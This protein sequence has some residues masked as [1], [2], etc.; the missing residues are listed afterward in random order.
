MRVATSRAYDAELT[1]YNLTRACTGTGSRAEARAQGEHR[2]NQLS[3]LE[4]HIDTPS[5]NWKAVVSGSSSFGFIRFCITAGT[6]A[7]NR[8]KSSSSVPVIVIVSV[9]LLRPL[10]SASVPLCVR[11]PFYSLRSLSTHEL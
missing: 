9:Q 1:V 3:V 4:K 5:S 10:H 6:T 11:R 7:A 8:F 2:E